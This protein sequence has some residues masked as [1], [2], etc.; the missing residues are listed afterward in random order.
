MCTNLVQFSL[1]GSSA[2]LN[3]TSYHFGAGGL[4]GNEILK[5]L[6]S[7][8]S[9]YTFCR[10]EIRLFLLTRR[11]SSSKPVRWEEWSEHHVRDS[12][13]Y[14]LVAFSSISRRGSANFDFFSALND[15]SSLSAL[16]AYVSS[17]VLHV[18]SSLSNNF[19]SFLF[20]V[21]L[22]RLLN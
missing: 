2:S 15:S 19:T 4:R 3:S 13:W 20:M 8:S 11:C 18:F 9:A 1:C 12:A 10:L 22:I 5:Q 7:H 17:S 6:I 21:N 16:G 14:N